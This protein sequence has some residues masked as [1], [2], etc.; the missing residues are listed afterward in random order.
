MKARFW[1]CVVVSFLLSVTAGNT[2]SV[3]HSQEQSFQI[4]DWEKALNERQPPVQ[5][6]NAIG[7]KQGMI[8]GEV[9]A[10]TGRM[11]VWLAD[12]V[13]DSGKVYANDIERSALDHLKRRCRRDGFRNVEIVVGKMEN[14]GFPASSLDMAFMINVYHHLADPVPILRNLVPSLKPDGILA[15]VECDPDKVDW[16]EE[17]GCSG[18]QNMIEHLKEAGFQVIRIET[19]LEEDS[20]YIAKPLIPF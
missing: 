17:H 10:G 1:G 15:I 9:G 11:T 13:G 16:G 6:M 5:I 8:V 18:K 14:P 4:E 3:T 19:F 7:L 12:R 20:I 2:I